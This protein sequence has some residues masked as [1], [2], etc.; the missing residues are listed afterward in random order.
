VGG[1]GRKEGRGGGV[2]TTGSPGRLTGVEVGLPGF[3]VKSLSRTKPPEQ[4]KRGRNQNGKTGCAG[5]EKTR[6][7]KKPHPDL[8]QKEQC[9]KGRQ[10]G[11][12]GGGGDSH[13]K[14]GMRRREKEGTDLRHV[15]LWGSK[16]SIL[17]EG[18]K[19]GQVWGHLGLQKKTKGGSSGKKWGGDQD[20][21]TGKKQENTAG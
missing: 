6:Q 12:K 11:N 3:R 14:G 9:G 17:M 15:G 10:R 19:K 1:G 21:L 8:N 20:Q 5:W 4:R 18:L 16:R 13:G 7:G 2:H